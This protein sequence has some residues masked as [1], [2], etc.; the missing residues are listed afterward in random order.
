MELGPPRVEEPAKLILGTLA[1][2]NLGLQF[3][4]ELTS[5]GSVRAP[6]TLA[7]LRGPLLST[8]LP[9]GQGIRSHCEPDGVH[10]ERIQGP[11]VGCRMKTKR[12]KS[13][14]ATW[15]LHLTT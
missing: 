3:G 4:S 9:E 15:K 6:S 5:T 2:G 13:I 7:R 11:G 14:R 12:R 8:G 10:R 1:L